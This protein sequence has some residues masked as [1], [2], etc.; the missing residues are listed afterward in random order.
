MKIIGVELRLSVRDN[1]GQGLNNYEFKI[2]PLD[3]VIPDDM[4]RG[5]M[6]N[7]KRAELN[8]TVNTSNGDVT[9]LFMLPQTNDYEPEEYKKLRASLEA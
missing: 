1:N 8:V 9:Q 7:S 4:I 5:S 3:L 6:W 2:V